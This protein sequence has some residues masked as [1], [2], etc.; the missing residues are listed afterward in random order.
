M[1]ILESCVLSYR[2]GEVS[3]WVSPGSQAR[4]G[5]NSFA[6]RTSIRA[7][8]GRCV[9]A[10]G[11]RFGP[12]SFR[13][14]QRAMLLAGVLVSWPM[15]ATQAHFIRPSVASTFSNSAQREPD[16]RLL[17]PGIPIERELAG[18]QAH[19]YQIT[20]AADQY[21]L[22][23]VD[24]RGI[25]VV[26]QLLGPDDK[27]I[28]EF[29][30]EIR[31]Q[32][33]EPVSHVTEVS[34][35]YRLNLRVKQ[36]VTQPGRY[37]IRVVEVRAATERDRTLQEGRLLLAE[38]VRLNVAGKYAEALPLLERVLEIREKTLAPGDP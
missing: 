28:L 21:L 6:R 32:G 16:V 5:D 17:E 1:S 9:M 8:R 35:S 29:D 38:G 19:S 20:L 36:E 18:G 10:D 11:G 30:S 4:R 31:E 3:S 13:L 2:C 25:D 22:A 26:V 37:E 33:Q 14:S 34:G 15:S 7:L 27:Q 12:I 23:V 24:Q